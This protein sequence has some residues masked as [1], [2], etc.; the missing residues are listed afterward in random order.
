[1]DA[2]AVNEE[3]VLLL[4]RTFLSTTYDLMM[5]IHGYGLWQAG[6]DHEPAIRDL[7]RFCQA[8]QHQRA[9]RA[10][11]AGHLSSRPALCAGALAGLLKVWPQVKLV[12]THRHVS[13]VLPPIARCAPAQR[14]FPQT[15][16]RK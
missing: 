8:I 11:R 14:Q 9:A 3:V 5:P 12:M 2:M 13:E 6:E 15:T 10:C 16:Y 4:D 7:K 1:M